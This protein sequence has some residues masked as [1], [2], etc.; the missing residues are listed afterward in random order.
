MAK[1][2]KSRF[3]KR[4]AAEIGNTA[5]RF[6]PK[7]RRFWAKKPRPVSVSEL[8]PGDV[9]FFY[10]KN[11]SIRGQ[12]F[13]LVTGCPFF[14]AAIYA[15]NGKL[16][17]MSFGQVEIRP[18]TEVIR[19]QV[20]LGL[21]PFV[22]RAGLSARQKKAVAREALA[23]EGVPFARDLNKVIKVWEMLGIKVSRPKKPGLICTTIVSE[24][25]SKAGVELVSGV[26]PKRIGLSH[27]MKSKK[28]K[29]IN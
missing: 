19:G 6:H 15:G 18:A 2:P 3:A 5:R 12:L 26:H 11:P 10:S 4:V 29:P 9:L 8:L 24:A 27:L 28:L 21:P 13:G 25:L 20:E 22:F 17:N 7:Y 16:A 1:E 23:L 14:H